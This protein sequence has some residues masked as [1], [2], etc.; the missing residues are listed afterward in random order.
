MDANE[1]GPVMIEL[2]LTRTWWRYTG[3]TSWLG[4]L[5]HWFNLCEGVT[6]LV[7]AVLVLRRRSRGTRTA[8]ECWYALAFVLFGCT[9]FREAWAQ[10]SW[11]LWLKLAN[12][13][14]LLAIRRRVM[15]ELYPDARLF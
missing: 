3:A 14:W 8:C 10:Q 9:D 7:F 13:I 5:Y 12:L 2:L 4:E 11:L 6:W 15:K 1:A